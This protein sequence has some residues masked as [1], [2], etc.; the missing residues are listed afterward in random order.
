MEE[1]VE[2]GTV[3]KEVI[4]QV[5]INCK[6]TMPVRDTDQLKGHTGSALHGVFV[7]AGGAKAAVTAERNKFKLSAVGAAIHGSAKGRV[8]TVDHLIDIF[9]LSIRGMKRIFNLFIIVGK[10]FL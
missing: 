3:L 7:S 1:A 10:N 8:T 2:Q 6:N 5:F 9:H 4:A